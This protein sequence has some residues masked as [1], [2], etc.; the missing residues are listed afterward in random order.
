MVAGM[1]EA[2][3]SPPKNTPSAFSLHWS[4]QALEARGT[5]VGG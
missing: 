5:A 2:S 4:S 3:S 1:F